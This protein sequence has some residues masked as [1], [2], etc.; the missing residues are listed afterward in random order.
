MVTCVAIFIIPMLFYV[1]ERMAHPTERKKRLTSG[2]A[3]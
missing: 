1:I 3:P 2:T